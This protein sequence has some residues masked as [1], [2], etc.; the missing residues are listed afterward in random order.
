MKES[1]QMSNTGLGILW[2]GAAISLAEILTGALLAPIGFAKGFAAIV[3]GHL[4]GCF[5]LY[6]TGVIGSSSGLPAIESTKIS[7]GRYGAY[8]FAILNLMQLLG[9]TGVMI[10]NGAQAFDI[11]TVSAFDYSNITLWCV[12][13]AVLICLWILVGFK[14]LTK[15][16][17]IAVGALLVFTLILGYMI[18]FTGS[19]TAVPIEGAMSFGAALE[20]S[21]IMPLSWLP[22]IADYTRFGN[23]KNTGAAFSA[24]GY[25]IGSVFMYT[26][27]LGGALFAGTS[28]ISAI[29]LAAGLPAIALLMVLFSTVTTTFLDAY[30]AAVSFTVLKKA[31]EKAVSV[32]ICFIGM[33][34]AI[35]VPASYYEWFLYLIG[36]AFAP[37][38]AILLTDYFILKKRT[39]Y[40]GNLRYRNAV[41]WL[42]GVILYRFMMNVDTFL[43]SSI[44]TMLILIVL[45]LLTNQ[46]SEKKKEGKHV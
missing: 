36:T 19:G 45:C 9:W 42:I 24:A 21:I 44:P 40:E 20:L 8:L 37:L 14:N 2:F 1:N 12:L 43:G 30:S 3:L 17:G 28:D 15:I 41:I 33:L 39:I 38:F 4:I 23:G 18:F 29:L 35:F 5:I 34:L 26:I 13:T 31:N 32:A 27:G 16:N 25:F 46:I 10:I 22:L 11:I 6:L 7:F